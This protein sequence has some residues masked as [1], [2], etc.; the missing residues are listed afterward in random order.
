[1]TTQ[2]VVNMPQPIT[3]RVKEE[4]E[5]AGLS[6]KAAAKQ[7]GMSDS[8]LGL[9]LK[10][11]YQDQVKAETIAN[12]ENDLE[13]WLESRAAKQA[14]QAVLKDAPPYFL[15]PTSK[16]IYSTLSYAQLAADIVIIHGGAGLGK[17]QSIAEYGEKNP[18]VW[19]LEATPTSCTMGGFLRSVA[20]LI[21]LRLPKAHHD[22][23]EIMVKER[24]LKTNGLLI[25]DEAQFLND[26]ALE[27]A[28]R[29]CELANIGLALVGN[30]TVY[31]QMTGRTRAAEFAQLFSRI[32]KRLKLT[33]PKAAD[34][35]AMCNAW[36]IDGKDEKELINAIANK[37]GALRMVTK[38]LRY[39]SL[40]SQ[41][42]DIQHKH[43]LAAWNDLGGEQ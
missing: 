20:T 31:T 11:K 37:P 16:R 1:M 13:K 4:I 12:L 39:A 36:N 10:G 28:R 32:G 30:D 8:K 41:G 19:V 9:Y 22:T 18:N 15:T 7:M 43:I 40:M 24:L 29:L 5:K 33:K 26:R 3:I 35:Q 34:I 25:V 21:E 42:N 2:K 23:L 27:Q 17:T 38:T 14:Q 6:I